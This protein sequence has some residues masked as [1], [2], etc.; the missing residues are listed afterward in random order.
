MNRRANETLEAI[1]RALYRACFV[2]Q[3]P[4]R[5]KSED[6]DRGPGVAAGVDL[7]DGVRQQ[8]EAV[9]LA[10]AGF[11]AAMPRR[12][13]WAPRS[14]LSAASARKI[15]CATTH[16]ASWGRD[17]CAAVRL[18]LMSRQ[19]QDVPLGSTGMTYLVLESAWTKH[20]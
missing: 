13:A 9:A 6:R 1:T 15:D 19:S 7:S 18:L 3:D 12:R 16:G 14:A 20:S 5:A 11:L 4:V 8:P 17:C 2:D 10:E